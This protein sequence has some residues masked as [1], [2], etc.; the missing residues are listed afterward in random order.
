MCSEKEQCREPGQK[1]TYYVNILHSVLV[2]KFLKI[3]TQYTKE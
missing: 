3:K 1:K 2:P